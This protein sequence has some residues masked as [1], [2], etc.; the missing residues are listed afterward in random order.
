MKMVFCVC[1]LL[2]SLASGVAEEVEIIGYNLPLLMDNP[3]KGL[4]IDLVK[5]IGARADMSINFTLLQ[6]EQIP[7]AIKSQMIAITRDERDL[8]FPGYPSKPIYLSKSFAFHMENTPRIMSIYNLKGRKI[9]ISSEYD[10]A[11]D[12][13]NQLTRHKV[14]IEK[15]KSDSTLLRYLAKDQVEAL[16][17]EEYSGLVALKISTMD[18]IVYDSH[19]PLWK[20]YIYVLFPKTEIGKAQA[21]RFNAGLRS[22]HADG[23]Y[24]AYMDTAFDMLQ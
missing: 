16:I 20:E 17:M 3:D 24:E 1:L 11:S 12:F 9:G 10:L 18:G 23:S 19:H 2:A 5:V 15:G 6:K 4:L 21:E 14:K 7:E 8:G 13:A 22:M